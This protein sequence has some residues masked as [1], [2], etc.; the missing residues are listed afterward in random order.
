MFLHG[1]LLSSILMAG[2][3]FDAQAAL[4]RVSAAK[5]P[6][7]EETSAGD[8]ESYEVFG[9]RYR[10]HASSDGYRERG[11]ASWYGHPFDG[12]PTSSGEMYDMHEMTAAHR[13]LP[14]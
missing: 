2:W 8:P 14:I 3:M 5:T 9:K 13:S 4:T 11:I 12:R 10:V 6:R 7:R 1:M